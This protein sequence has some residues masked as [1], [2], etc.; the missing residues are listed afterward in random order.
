MKNIK[1]RTLDQSGL[2]EILEGKTPYFVIKG[3][4]EGSLVLMQRGGRLIGAFPREESKNALWT[5]PKLEAIL[6]TEEWNVGGDR[7]WISPERDFF[8]ED[9]DKFERWF[10]PKALDPGN[11]ELAYSKRG[12]VAF[13]NVLNLSNLRTG[14]TYKDVCVTR[15]MSYLP[16]PYASNP[17]LTKTL[18]GVSYVG[19]KS[20]EEVLVKENYLGLR[21]NPWV[22][23]QVNPSSSKNPGVVIVPTRGAD[24]QPIH[25]FGRIPDE[26][27]KVHRDHFSFK[28][29]G[30]AVYKLGIRPEDLPLKRE[31]AIGYIADVEEANNE[32]LLLIRKSKNV[33]RNQSECLDP[34]KANPNGPKGAI[35]S[36]N[37]GL[38]L[39]LGEVELQLSPVKRRDHEYY[40]KARA[41]LLIFQGPRNKIVELAKTLLNVSSI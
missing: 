3:E 22:I 7:L 26:R 38:D 36:Y 33:P 11:Y 9:A 23:T 4:H 18:E 10:C 13:R 40:R 34:A 5:N 41:D 17:R 27:L 29:D 25:Y 24:A 28:I 20:V 8:Y 6:N 31:A 30:E 19:M 35:Q 39:R 12:T 2:T 16:N 15:T 1:G 14:E 21:I 32:S 37:S